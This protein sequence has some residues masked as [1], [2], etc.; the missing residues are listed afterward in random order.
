MYI[1]QCVHGTKTIY[2]FKA[3]FGII[4]GCMPKIGLAKCTKLGEQRAAS[5]Q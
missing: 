4:N 5:E 3:C 2:S 1:M